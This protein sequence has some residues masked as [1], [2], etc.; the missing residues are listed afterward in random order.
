MSAPD[1]PLAN[2]SPRLGIVHLLGWTL[3]VAIV[4]GVYRAA[5]AWQSQ[6]GVT[7]PMSPWALGFGLAY[8]TALGGLGLFLWRWWRG[9]GSGPTQPGHW[10]LVLGGIGFLL[11][12]G[13]VPVSQAL[14]MLR[15]GSITDYGH[16]VWM[17]HQCLGWL[18]ATLVGLIVLFN[19]RGASWGWTIV[20]LLFVLSVGLVAGLF[21]TALAAA[22]LGALGSWTWYLP[23]AVKTIGAAVVVTAIL[24]AEL[25]DRRRGLSRDWLH[26]GGIL[27]VSLLASVD[28]A[29]NLRTFFSVW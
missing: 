12:V 22:Q 17:L 23:M 11:D 13:L 18:A 14:V 16:W 9:T 10:L 26:T 27:A 15:Y 8:G 3:G 25:A 28:I 4:L 24:A 1:A 6:D 19:L 5:N 20:A 29:I 7:P 21:V 2:H